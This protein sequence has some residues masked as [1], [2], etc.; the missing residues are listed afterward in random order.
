VWWP[1]FRPANDWELESTGEWH[2]IQFSGAMA[3]LVAAVVGLAVAL[4]VRFHHK[5]SGSP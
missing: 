3:G 4:L 2:A 1:T 5:A